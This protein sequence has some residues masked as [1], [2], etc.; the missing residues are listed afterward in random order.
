MCADEE[1]LLRS[2]GNKHMAACHFPLQTPVEENGAGP[3]A[4]AAPAGDGSG[5]ATAPAGD[6]ADV[7][8]VDRSP[9]DG[10]STS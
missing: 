10:P 5:T 1:P 7:A 3:V 8:G 9:T 2:F 6:R 4:A